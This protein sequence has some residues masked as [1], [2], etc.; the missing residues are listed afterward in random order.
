MKGINYN[1]DLFEK[2][3]KALK[4]FG[5]PFESFRIKPEMIKNLKEY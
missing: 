3:E 2:A 5:V 4:E 1:N